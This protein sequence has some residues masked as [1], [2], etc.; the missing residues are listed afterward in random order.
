MLLVDEFWKAIEFAIVTR[1][2]EIFVKV[3][4]V[5][6]LCLL[7]EL[8]PK[9]TKLKVKMF[10]VWRDLWD[11]SKDYGYPSV[12]LWEDVYITV[13]CNQRSNLLV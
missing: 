8:F 11:K 9:Y 4:L 1:R 13:V 3:L 6:D 10:A 5:Y 7:Q 2:R 12:Y